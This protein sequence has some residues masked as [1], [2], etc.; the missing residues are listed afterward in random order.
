MTTG[1]VLLGVGI[2]ILG[3]GGAA[4]MEYGLFRLA[5]PAGLILIV[6]GVVIRLVTGR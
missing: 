6:I 2:L 4:E 3:A 5:G 1:L